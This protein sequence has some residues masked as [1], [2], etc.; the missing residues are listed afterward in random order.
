MDLN[1]KSSRLYFS[2]AWNYRNGLDQAFLDTLQAHLS[3]L[4]APNLNFFL[5]EKPH[6][7]FLFSGMGGTHGA[8]VWRSQDSLVKL[9][10]LPQ[11][12]LRCWDSAC[13]IKFT[14][15]VLSLLDI[16]KNSN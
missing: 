4:P 8:D 16:T 3:F 1:S 6:L 15:L 7:L 10:F 12:S 9:G 13:V 2:S 11:P 14:E 5:F